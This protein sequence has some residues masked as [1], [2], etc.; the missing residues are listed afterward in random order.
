MKTGLE[1]APESVLKPVDPSRNEI[2]LDVRPGAARVPIPM[3]AD[4]I[5]RLLT[6][7]RDGAAAAEGVAS[8]PRLAGA[9]RRVVDDI[10]LGVSPARARTRVAALELHASQVAGALGVDGALGP[11][12]GRRAVVSR[13]ARAGRGTSYVPA[14]RVG[15]A[16]GRNARVV[17]G[18]GLSHRRRWRCNEIRKFRFRL[19]KTTGLSVGRR[20]TT[21]LRRSM[22]YL[23]VWRRKYLR[24]IGT[25][26]VKGSPV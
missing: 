22:G 16:R 7:R 9:H 3:P 20:P 4:D 5:F 15:P 14:L 2:L 23:Y 25:H 1:K 13:P 10:A 26:L 6:R 24:G 18:W 8:V 11:A 17:I 19:E 21:Q 12:V